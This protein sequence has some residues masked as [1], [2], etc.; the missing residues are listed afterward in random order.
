MKKDIKEVKSL[1]S[2]AL[3]T[4]WSHRYGRTYTVR[5]TEVEKRYGTRKNLIVFGKENLTWSELLEYAYEF[6]STFDTENTQWCGTHEQFD[7]YDYDGKKIGIVYPVD[8][9]C[10][11]I[12]NHYHTSERKRPEHFNTYS[13]TFSQPISEDPWEDALECAKKEIEAGHWDVTININCLSLGEVEIVDSWDPYA[14]LGI[15]KELQE[16]EYHLE[17]LKEKQNHI[18]EGWS[19]RPGYED[20][21][22]KVTQRIQEIA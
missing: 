13:E 20:E 21:I 19:S 8:Y 3:R 14:L 16:L 12:Y 9:Q 10:E 6:E 22:Q 1:E 2:P 11:V 4:L 15:N 17:S 18:D 7:Y 5:L